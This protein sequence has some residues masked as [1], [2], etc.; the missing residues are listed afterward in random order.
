MP[1]RYFQDKDLSDARLMLLKEKEF[2]DILRESGTHVFAYR[3][4]Y[5]KETYPG[6]YE[7]VHWMASL[8]AEQ[9]TRPSPLCWGFRASLDD[10]SLAAANGGM[11]IILLQD[12]QSYTLESLCSKRR[13]HI[14]KCQR[15]VK[16]VQLNGEPAKAL[17][18]QQGYQIFAS[19][20]KRFKNQKFLS[21]EEYLQKM[22]NYIDSGHYF[23]MGGILGNEL[24]GYL[25]AIAIDGTAYM[26]ERLVRTDALKT[27]LGSTLTFEF[28]QLCKRFGNIREI[29]SGQHSPEKQS[30]TEFKLSMGFQVTYV[31]VK[32]EI[33]PIIDRFIRWRYPNKYYRL[34]GPTSLQTVNSQQSIG[35][36]E[37][38]P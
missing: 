24:I 34:K 38:F 19:A 4:R 17:L 10:N 9:A 33:N 30:L 2:A 25:T 23:V 11:P 5:W 37:H 14:R 28:A 20:M 22:N 15:R 29:V 16:L 26:D 36:R 13:S 6:F 27:D 35:D 1:I 8:K 31:P 3:D 32:V 12:L 21:R 7:P 18:K